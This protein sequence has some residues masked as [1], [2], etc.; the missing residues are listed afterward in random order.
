MSLAKLIV[1][2][3]VGAA[4]NAFKMN[5][6]VDTIKEELISITATKIE[7]EIPVTLPFDTRSALK[8][9][10]II[11]TNLL[12]PENLQLV[13]EIPEPIK[14]DIRATLDEIESVL[15]NTIKTKNQL[16]GNLNTLLKPTD[17]L[18]LFA[19]NIGKVI[20]ALNGIVLLIK[21]LP[22]PTSVPPGVGLPSSVLTNFADSLD[23]LKKQIDKL[24]GPVKTVNSSIKQIQKTITPIVGKLKLLDPIFSSATTIII[25]IKTLLDYGPFATEQQINEVSN[26]VT[27]NIE[28]SLA[29]TSGPIVSQSS[30]VWIKTFNSGNGTSNSPETPPPTPTSPFTSRNGDVWTFFSSNQA[31]NDFLLS[32]LTQPNNNPLIYKDYKLQIETDPNNRFSF[33][34]RRILATYTI[35]EDNIEAQNTT[36][37]FQL[38]LVNSTVYNLP[39]KGYSFSSSVQAL[40]AETYYEIDQFISGQ[41][42]IQTQINSEYIYDAKGVAVGR[43]PGFPGYSLGPYRREIPNLG[44]KI[45]K[46]ILN[47][48]Y[49]ERFVNDQ[50]DDGSFLSSPIIIQGKTVGQKAINEILSPTSRDGIIAGSFIDGL[51]T[52]KDQTPYIFESYLELYPDAKGEFYIEKVT[53]PKNV[54][55]TVDSKSNSSSIGSPTAAVTPPPPPNPFYPFDRGGVRNGERLY[56]T[57]PNTNPAV[58][59]AYEWDILREKWILKST[60]GGTGGGKGGTARGPL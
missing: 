35:N 21:N 60:S 55:A 49:F 15:N 22:I 45:P 1:G 19:E 33:P 27:S 34:S 28:E 32:Q 37:N 43:K 16:Q 57:I 46:S 12:T 39:D 26:L 18:A 3:M 9:D 6:I 13:S 40:I 17:T 38:R 31:A 29:S 53:I 14:N 7:D 4:K 5:I 48:S 25:F 23:G 41:Q 8:G 54:N 2:Q 47:T 52:P 20:P 10:V 56:Y 58:I 50:A 51:F 42:S 44:Q 30:G 11:N 36:I 24:D 59:R